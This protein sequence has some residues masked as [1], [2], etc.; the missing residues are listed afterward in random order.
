MTPRPCLSR[1]RLIVAVER[2][3]QRRL[4]C[5]VFAKERQ[6]FAAVR[7]EADIVKRLYTGEVFGNI[8]ELQCI[9]HS[10]TPPVCFFGFR[11][12]PVFTD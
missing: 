1:G 3:E 9:A 4:S 5:A 6:H 11:G 2:F 8:A 7:G 10:I 12:D